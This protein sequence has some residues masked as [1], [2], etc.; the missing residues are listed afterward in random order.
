MSHCKFEH[1]RHG[2]LGMRPHGR[3][4]AMKPKL[5]G[6]QKDPGASVK[7]YFTAFLGYKVGM[8]QVIRKVDRPELKKLHTKEVVEPVT[9]LETPA[10]VVVGVRGYVE[11]PTGLQCFATVYAQ[12][13]SEEFRRRLIKNWVNS[14]KKA[15]MHYSKDF[16]KPEVK[17]ALD[18]KIEAMKKTCSVIKAIVHTQPHKISA[19]GMKKA[20]IYQVPIN[21]GTIAE[22]VDF[23]VSKFEQEYAIDDMVKE[24]QVVDVA[25]IT[26]GKGYCGV[27]K[28]FH[29]KRLQRKTRRGRR[30][31]ACIGSWH[32]ANVQSTVPRGGQLGYFHRVIKNMKIYAIKNGADATSGT[33]SFD[34]TQKSINPMGGGFRGYGLIKNKCLMLKGSVMGTKK[35]PILVKLPAGIPPKSMV[36]E[37]I[38]L[39]FIDTCSRTGH[40][41]FQTSAEKRASMGLLK[42]DVAAMTQK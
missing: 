25:G 21:G 29:V 26:T 23:V 10:S 15:F 34:R 31:V 6:Y 28:R 42:K 3:A 9:Y 1:P 11:T 5:R 13:L 40:S 30:K 36:N 24:S 20:H 2:H 17:K 38:D 33:T 22:K 14:S 8:T 39:K 19:L 37:K 41:R 32:P 27:V 35:R 4:R 7:P 12:H 16:A 18:D